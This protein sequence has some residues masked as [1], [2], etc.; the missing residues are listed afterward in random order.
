MVKIPVQ[1]C[2]TIRFSVRTTFSTFWTRTIPGEA[3]THL[4]WK[5]EARKRLAGSI[6]AKLAEHG[7]EA[8]EGG[9]AERT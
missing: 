4:R 2:C 7:I 6:R 1:R 9:H 8:Y 3:R 5:D